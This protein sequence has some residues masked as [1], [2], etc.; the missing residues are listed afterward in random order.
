MRA[1]GKQVAVGFAANASMLAF[2]LTGWPTAAVAQSDNPEEQEIVI[3]AER[4]EVALQNT[5]LAASS[6]TTKD[7]ERKSV[8]SIADLQY[9]TPSLSIIETGFS[10]SLNI[11]GI[12]LAVINPAVVPGI[13]TYR[14][15]VFLSSQTT[16]GEPFF[17]IASV[18]VLRGP[19]G[20]FVGQNAT[21]GAVFINSRNPSINEG[22]RSDFTVQYGNYDHIQLRG[23][24]NLPASDTFALRLAFNMEKRDSFFRNITSKIVEPGKLDIVNGRVG[25]L[26]QPT[27]KLEVLFKTQYNEGST[28]GYAYKP[29]IGTRYAPLAPADPFTLNYD[30]GDTRLDTIYVRSSLQIDYRFGSGLRLRSISGYQYNNEKLLADSDATTAN[31]WNTNHFVERTT[32]QDVSVISPDEG[33]FRWVIGGTFAHYS[34][35]VDVFAFNPVQQLKIDLVTKKTAWGAFVN[36]TYSLLD[37]L[38]VEAGA[39]Y[40]GD[41]VKNSGGTRI[42]IVGLPNPILLS[43][44]SAAPTGSKITGKVA[45]NWKV[46]PDHLL[47]AFWARGY[48]PGGVDLTGAQFNEE[49]VDDYEI[50]WKGSL[51]NKRLRIQTNAYLMKYKGFQFSTFDPITTQTA[52]RNAGDSTIKG[53]EASAQLSLGALRADVGLAYTDSKIGSIRL[54][55]TR[56][57]PNGSTAGL[58]PQ[59]RPGG[60]ARC[61]DY[62]P[63]T[64]DV[65]GSS[66]IYSPR[67][68]FNAGME[69]GFRF[70][71][72]KLT[73]R[74]DVSYLSSQWGTLFEDPLLDK[75]AARTLVNLQLTYS[76]DKWTIEGFGTNITNKTYISGAS[77]NNRFY[78]APREYGVR[79]SRSF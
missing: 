34:D 67:W 32:T 73:P 46:T 19:Q 6:L 30:R 62:G 17:D 10:K 49:S 68:T 48:K 64:V 13:A 39:R 37:H 28:D 40:S 79:I 7:L 51:L 2:A 55:N 65:S 75:F 5:N 56:L 14:D 44:N 70:A 66:N 63:F 12:G 15:G 11:R 41:K 74:I 77:G 35:T 42:S 38:D 47:F 36:G 8:T 20:T 27:S 78:G 26:W 29:A 3:T 54:V 21:G 31:E 50:G 52:I 43:L 16:Y 25:F 59:C 45:L 33:R 57:L 22:V 9:A 4:R 23:A 53:F 1:R 71:G 24:V 61:F 69:Y 60:P 72:G 58:P 18:E 76:R